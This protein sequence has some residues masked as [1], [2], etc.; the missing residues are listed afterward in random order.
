MWEYFLNIERGV[1]TGVFASHG[2][3]K[4]VPTWLRDFNTV[5]EKESYIE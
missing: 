2:N 1:V 3:G 4:N 5:Q